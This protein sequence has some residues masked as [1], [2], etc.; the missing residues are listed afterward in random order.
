MPIFR[1]NISRKVLWLDISIV[2]L[3]TMI[4][5]MVLSVALL[6]VHNPR[7]VIFLGELIPP[8]YYSKYTWG[9]LVTVFHSYLLISSGINGSFLLSL[10]LTYGVYVNFIVTNE[11]RLDAKHYRSIDKIREAKNLMIVY[12]SFQI[13][14]ANVWVF[15]GYFLLYFHSALMI[16]PIYGNSALIKYW[17]FLDFISVTAIVVVCWGVFFIW[18]LILQFGKYMYIRGENTLFSWKRATW[19]NKMEAKQM[20]KFRKSCQPVL[21]RYGNL[22]VIGRITQFKFVKGVVRGTFR[23]LLALTGGLKA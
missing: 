18:I 13:I 1:P 15:G 16:L 2:S 6:C 11:L 8:E 17:N 9:A 3:S 23:S 19:R 14:N 5:F 21:F 20:A 22:F 4:S 10:I 12:R 7:E